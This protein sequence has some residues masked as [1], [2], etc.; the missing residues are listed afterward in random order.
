MKMIR[1][2][3][4]WQ[5]NFTVYTKRYKS[6]M[7]LNF[8]EPILYLIALGFGLGAFV[9]DINGIPYIRFIA[10]GLIAS[11]SMFASSFECTYGTYIRMTYQ[12]TFEAILATPVN[13][14][15]L[16]FGE[17]MWG[18]AKGTLYG[19]TIMLVVSAFSLID[20][21]FIVITIPFIFIT[22][23]I[24]AEIGVI[25]SATVPG[26]DS[27]NYFNTLFMTPMFLFSGIFF[28][29][30]T[31]PAVV[32]K[33]AFFTPLYHLV[34]ICRSFASGNP[35]SAGWDIVWIILVALILAPYPFRLMRKR[36]LD[37]QKTI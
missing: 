12:K 28:P 33:I 37:R 1:A 13:I 7:V 34:N 9:K 3:R 6:S 15:D 25:A 8:V 10:P 36:I 23:L 16:V 35:A 19:T 27:F 31:L 24:F 29:V 26:I 30:D 21:F 32:S 5:R 11:S 14:D 17:I 22:G 20:S 2:Y 18:A 4:V